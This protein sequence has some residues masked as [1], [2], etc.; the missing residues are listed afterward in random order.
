LT[1][2]YQRTYEES[3]ALIK[4]MLKNQRHEEMER[5]M[6]KQLLEER[7]FTIYD[8]TLRML[9]AEQAESL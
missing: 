9:L 4:T 5:D 1:E 7:G 8:K 3:A 2:Q 6:E